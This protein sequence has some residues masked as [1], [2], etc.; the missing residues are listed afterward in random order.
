MRKYIVLLILISLISCGKWKT[1]KLK[2]ESLCIFPPGDSPGSI[3]L[4]YDD[5]D[6]LDVSFKVAVINDN[7]Y[8]ADNIS[9]SLQVFNNKCE[10]LLYI[11]EKKPTEIEK[12]NAKY[13]KFQFSIIDA[14]KT[15]SNGNIYIQNSFTPSQKLNN[16]LSG[17]ESGF[18]LSY[19]LVFDP[20][21]SLLYTLGRTG[22]PDLPFTSIESLNIDKNDR[23]FVI[24]RSYD[25]WD[26]Y[27]FS[28]RRRDLSI[29]FI[30][31]DFKETDG[32]DALTGKIEKIIPFKS[33]EDLMIAVGFYKGIN[34]QYRK[35]FRYTIQKEMKPDTSFLISDPNN[36]FFSILDDKQIYLW[37]INDKQIRY[38]VCNLNGDIVN[39][40][41]IKFPDSNNFFEDIQMDNSGNFYSYHTSKKGIE[42]M[43]WR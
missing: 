28:N 31:T 37:D 22:S 4:K 8:A 36:E 19:I 35:I 2:P 42:V 33:G 15:D 10:L 23:L 38:M 16:R 26:I 27:R 17:K 5:D 41:S 13:S 9:T 30:E 20:N 21:G 1:S 25:T 39:N 34:F 7:I 40:I 14:V 11:G 18:S 3:M 32:K 12:S 6:I 43:E 24:T 29:N